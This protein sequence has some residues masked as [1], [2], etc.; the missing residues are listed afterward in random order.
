MY[1]RTS[2]S[3]PVREERNVQQKIDESK[4]LIAM[5]QDDDEKSFTKQIGLW[6]SNL[7]ADVNSYVMCTLSKE[8]AKKMH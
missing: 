6:K 1:S 3:A 8:D 2:V 5:K 7:A 4:K